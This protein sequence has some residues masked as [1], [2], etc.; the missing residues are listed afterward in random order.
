MSTTT[1][2][3]VAAEVNVKGEELDIEAEE[4]EQDAPS[5]QKYTLGKEWGV[6]SEFQSDRGYTLARRTAL[7]E[8]EAS[9]GIVLVHG[10]GEHCGRYKHVA[11]ALTG[12]GYAVFSSDLKG[13]GKSEGKRLYI[14][15]FMDFVRDVVQLTK[16]A[17]EEQPQIQKWFLVGHSMGSLISVHTCLTHPDLFAGVVL[18]APP[19]F[20]KVPPGAG[21]A[22]SIIGTLS[23]SAQL[24]PLDISTLCKDPKVVEEYLKDDLV[25]SGKPYARFL[26]QLIKHVPKARKAAPKFKTP[27]LLMHGTADT[28]C[29]PQGSQKFHA[30]TVI[31]D[32]TLKIFE[33]NYHELFNEP[34]IDATQELLNWVGARV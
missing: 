30:T 4:N 23:A 8:E 2:E 18:S 7:P 9:V 1:E 11:E 33:G 29:L 20:V 19:L 15:D 31:D 14:Y 17:K 6:E 13:H 10:M 34:D 3:Q 26:S 27:Y 21:I 16:I 5:K 25:S 28:M 22:A 32:K 24:D 12:A